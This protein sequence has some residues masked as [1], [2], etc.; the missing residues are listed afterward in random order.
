MEEKEGKIDRELMDKGIRRT[1]RGGGENEKWKR[2]Q[3]FR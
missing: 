3:T 1:Q 2:G